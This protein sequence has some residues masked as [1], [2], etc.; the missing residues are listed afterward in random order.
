MYFAKQL[1]LLFLVNQEKLFLISGKCL[2]VFLSKFTFNTVTFQIC[3]WEFYLYLKVLL[4]LHFK[5]TRACIFQNTSFSHLFMVAGLVIT[6]QLTR[7]EVVVFWYFSHFRVFQVS[8]IFDK[9]DTWCL[10][11]KIKSLTQHI[12]VGLVQAWSLKFKSVLVF[13]ETFK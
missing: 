2:K 11:G 8:R 5:S 6:W 7:W 4:L 13:Y 9:N 3:F 1:S 12:A 10:R